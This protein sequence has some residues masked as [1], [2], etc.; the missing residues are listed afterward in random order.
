MINLL[1]GYLRHTLQHVWFQVST[2]IYPL[3][4]GG[5]VHIEVQNISTSSPF[6]GYTI[7]LI[8]DPHKQT[9]GYNSGR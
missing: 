9:V 3:Y 5:V 8:V 2:R 6:A 1:L 7:I 4:S